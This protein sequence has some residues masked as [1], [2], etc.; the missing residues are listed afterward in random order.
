MID[1]GGQPSKLK[2]EEWLKENP[3]Y[4]NTVSCEKKFNP[5]FSLSQLHFH[6]FVEVS[7]IA[8]GCGIHRIWNRIFEC[9]KGDV[10]VLNAGV[11]H[12]YFVKDGKEKLVIQNLLF[13]AE[14]W[15]A[16]DLA[17]PDSPRFCYGIFD[18]NLL[19][20]YVT[21]KGRSMEAVEKIYQT[22][23]KE[24][25]EKNPEWMEVTKAQ[26]MLLLI[27]IK[28][29]LEESAA[30]GSVSPK[31][32]MVVSTVMRLVIER[33]SD[34]ELTLESIASSLFMSKSYLSK[35]FWR[36]TGEHF[37][38][39]LRSVRLQQ[40]CRLLRETQLT[41]EQIVYGCGLKDVPSF[42]QLFKAKLSM[43]PN[44]YR[45]ETR[46]ETQ[47]K[48]RRGEYQ[49][50]IL[51]DISGNLQRGKAKIVKELVQK[52]VDEGIPVEQILS[53]GLLDGMSVVGEKFKNNEVY[54]P[55]VLVAAR[56]MNMGAQILKP[57]MA[58][59]G[60]KATGKVCIGTVQGDL[61]DIGKNLVKM[62]MEGKGLE[63]VD[64]GTDVAPETYVQT[65]IEQNCQVICCSAL[66]TTT[67]GV[68]EEVVKKAEEAGIRDKVKIMIG[69]APVTEEYCQKI[70]ADK[71]TPDAA[72]AADA[73]VVL[74]AAG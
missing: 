5:D 51:T 24:T 60:V 6:E 20:A 38:E 25:E 23:E 61:H 52:A 44:R 37:S 26:L 13:D 18:E 10:Y 43:T 36:V 67:M 45:T 50:S 42:Y 15:F 54:V 57:L 49:M 73:A 34:K 12:E 71:Y 53:E 69:G 62:M 16:G 31:D 3:I 2:K 48:E 65:A 59:A 55:E 9:R 64:L 14:D 35:L 40:A 22:I 21:L 66:L 41:N 70:G 4:Q 56:A 58:E 72:S 11:P 19:S 33:Y 46:N 28:R 47:Y 30:D 29:H 68:M 32:R 7:I 1:S 63:V 74:C 8:E 27:T 39:Y 17:A